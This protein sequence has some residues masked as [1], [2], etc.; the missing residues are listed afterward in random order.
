[1]TLYRNKHQVKF[2]GEYMYVDIMQYSFYYGMGEWRFSD[3]TAFR[4]GLPI[5]L[6]QSFGTTG[7]Y[8]KVHNYSGF[9]QDEWQ[10]KSNLTI[11]Y[12]VRYDLNQLPGDLSRMELPEPA[13]NQVTGKF[14]TDVVS[15]SFMQGFKN[16]TN[17][18]QPRVGGS[19]SL[20]DKTVLRAAAGLFYGGAHYGEMAQGF[21]NS[22]D[23]YA[24][25]DFPATEAQTIW[26]GLHNPASPIYNGGR[27]RLSQ[28]YRQTLI[29]QNRLYSMSLHPAQL[30]MPRSVQANVGV[31]RQFGSWLSASASFLWNRGDGDYRSQNI[32][33]PAAVL[34][35]AGSIVPGIPGPIPFD[36]NFRPNEGPRAD[37]TRANI[38]T[39]TMVTRT[40]Y[41][42]ASV[43]LTARRGGL[44]MRG[45]YTYNDAWDDGSDVSTRLL[46]SDSDCVKCE[47]SKSVLSTTHNFRGAV[48]YLTPTSLPFYARGWQLSSIVSLESGTPVLTIASFDANGDNVVTDRPFGVPRTALI[49]D[50]YRNVDVRISRFFPTGGSTRL[51]VFFDMSNIFNTVNFNSYDANLYRL[52]GGRY[53]PYEDFASYAANADLLNKGFNQGREK[54]D[55]KEIGLDAKVRRTGTRAPRE[56]QLGF[57]FHF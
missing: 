25:Y 35:K 16:D 20:N 29:A 30:Q 2:G 56:G 54:I 19:Y 27:M 11:N 37:P 22:V 33:P 44:Q 51:E 3:L 13:F 24:R 17:N 48:V 57:R 32:N 26:A 6:V 9:I 49:S 1:M 39:Y 45:A 8:L 14:D 15:N 18:F 12:G 42:G 47:F 28:A 21:A 36:V 52:S 7:A 46:P 41:K 55:V 34:Y 53:V 23:G 31:E 40:R 50:P 43:G 4:A 5:G 10:P 38:Y